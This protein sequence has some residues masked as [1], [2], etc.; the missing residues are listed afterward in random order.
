MTK[1][2]ALLAVAVLALAPAAAFAHAHL[3][4]ASPA[5]SAIVAAPDSVSLG[6]TEALEKRFSAIEVRDAGGRR[7]DDGIIRSEADPAHLTIGLPHL[8]AGIYKVIWH[9]TSVD[10]HRTEGDFTFTVAP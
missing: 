2:R 8:P 4:S 6:F 3:A 5:Q 7:V 9:A 10:T 1:Q